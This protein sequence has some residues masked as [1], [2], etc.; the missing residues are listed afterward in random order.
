MLRW[1]VKVPELIVEGENGYENFSVLKC[2]FFFW[3]AGNG[4]L[5]HF[6]KRGSFLDSA[7]LNSIISRAHDTRKEKGKNS[8]K[9]PHFRKRPNFSQSTPWLKPPDF[10]TWN[11][12]S[13]V[14]HGVWQHPRVF[15][16]VMN[17]WISNPARGIRPGGGGGR[18][19]VGKALRK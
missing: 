10:V 15:S 13:R 17:Q 8:P 1:G 12:L 14:T 9:F 5:P 16:Q 18:M 6:F 4:S 7:T 11:R 19:T 3:F 2:I